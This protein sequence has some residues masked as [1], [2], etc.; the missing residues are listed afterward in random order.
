MMG[1]VGVG[2]VDDCPGELWCN[3]LMKAEKRGGITWKLPGLA[4]AR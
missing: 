2:A 3:A 4:E 1:A